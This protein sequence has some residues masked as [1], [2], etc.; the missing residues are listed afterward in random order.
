MRRSV[1]SLTILKDDMVLSATVSSPPQ[2]LP[3]NERKLVLQ[4]EQSEPSTR[5]VDREEDV[6]FS[7]GNLGFDW[8]S[9]AIKSFRGALRG[10]SDPTSCQRFEFCAVVFLLIVRRWR[11]S[12]LSGYGGVDMSNGGEEQ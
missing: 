3:R 2:C 11:S 10:L 12:P 8:V 7:T 1:A 4:L 6:S 5:D 9:A